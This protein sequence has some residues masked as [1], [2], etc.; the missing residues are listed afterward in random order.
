MHIHSLSPLS[1]SSLSF[2][3]SSV[4]SQT[5]KPIIVLYGKLSYRL[6]IPVYEQSSLN[7]SSS[8]KP[9]VILRLIV[10][11]AFI[12]LRLDC[13]TQIFIFLLTTHIF[14]HTLHGLLFFNRDRQGDKFFYI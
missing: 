7:I 1:L 11:L 2:S 13:T 10:I 6:D 9:I 3:L 5:V 14:A 4:P 8:S 12:I